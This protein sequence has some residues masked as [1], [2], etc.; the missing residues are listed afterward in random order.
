M[1]EELLDSPSDEFSSLVDEQCKNP[2][3]DEYW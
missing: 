3:H 1:S 2:K